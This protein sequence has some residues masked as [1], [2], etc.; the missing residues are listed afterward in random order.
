MGGVL[1]IVQS[2]DRGN[3][4]R[5]V[6]DLVLGL[7][8]RVAGVVTGSAGWLPETLRAGG[9]EVYPAPHLQRSKGVRDARTGRAEVL[10][11]CIVK[12]PDVIHAHGPAALSAALPAAKEVPLV[13]TAHGLA[14]PDPSQPG[15]QRG[16]SMRLQRTAARRVS[17][18]VALTAYEERAALEL[19][20]RRVL[21][22]PPGVARPEAAPADGD[23]GRVIGTAS[24]LVRGKGLEEIID[25]LTRIPNCQLLV[26]GEGPFEVELIERAAAAGVRDRVEFLGWLEDVSHFHRRISVYV[27]LTQEAGLPHG[28]LDAIA[29][30]LPVVLSD[31]PGH[32]KLVRHGLSGLLVRPGDIV[33]AAKAVDQI[34]RDRIFARTARAEALA[35]SRQYDLGAM[36]AR[37]AA[38]YEEVMVRRRMRTPRLHLRPGAG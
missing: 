11:I 6:R 25:A 21:R 33:H 32:R 37:H 13:Y 38:L 9:I 22:I 27:S 4:E 5:H 12:Q 15:W 16:L 3:M 8:D 26:V 28:A 34:L 7:K 29:A 17:A 23:R 30:G 20:F 31:V 14:L 36:L 24:E 1:H 19:G 10:D 18:F 2:R 35:I